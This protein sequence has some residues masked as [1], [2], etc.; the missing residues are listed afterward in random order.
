MGDEYQIT[1]DDYVHSSEIENMPGCTAFVDECGSFGFDFTTEGASK[2]YILC[3]VVV[4]NTKIAELRQAIDEIK[5]TN[6]YNGKE[7]KSNVIGNDHKR[8]TRIVTQ[9]LGIEFNVVLL[10]ADKQQFMDDSP[11]KEY[12]KSF[13]KYLHQRLY[14][15]LYH[16]FPKLK[17]IE[18]EIGRSEFQRSFRKYVEDRR[19]SLNLFNQYDFDYTDSK[20]ESLVQLADIIGGSINKALTMSDSPNYL[21]MLKSKIL[22]ID[23]FPT[24]A[25]PYWG[26][27]KPEDYKFDDS[28][29][30][31]AVKCAE[32][33]ISK[34][35]KEENEET[36]AQVAFL[37]YLLFQVRNYN[38]SVYI[39]SNQILAALRNYLDMPIARNF[40]YRRVV[41]PLRD[42]GV[43]IASCPQGY[44]IPISVDDIVTY[45]NQTHTIVSPMLYRMGKCRDLI[46]Q[47]TYGNLDILNDPAFVK[48][49]KYFDEL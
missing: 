35:A 9:L 32:D 27:A 33:F 28:I 45:L 43:L 1:I 3:A 40:L 41:A 44:K 23:N 16:P 49:K 37:K 46:L 48:Y 14:E 13:I 26:K 38:P 4:K 20:N 24:K 12:K 25:T 8:R 15:L 36:K 34:H 30:T 5:R 31:L 6:G 29:F 19:P 22:L 42:A 21:E 10:I 11:L 17:I 7:L 2:L 47:N 18:D 39:S